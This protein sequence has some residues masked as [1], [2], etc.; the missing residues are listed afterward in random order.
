L[1]RVLLMGTR[2]ETKRQEKA[3]QSLRAAIRKGNVRFG[4]L[5]VTKEG[6]IEQ[7]H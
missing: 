4:T 5:R 3:Q 1:K 6:K 2:P 7:E